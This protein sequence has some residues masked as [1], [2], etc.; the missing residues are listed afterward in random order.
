MQRLARIYDPN[1]DEP[2]SGFHAE[3]LEA[4]QR[5]GGAGSI[6]YSAREQKSPH[7]AAWDANYKDLLWMQKST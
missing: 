6:P 4:I 3:R 1:G 5:L 2:R 7:D